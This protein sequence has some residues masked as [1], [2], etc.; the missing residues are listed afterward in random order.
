MQIVDCRG[1]DGRLYDDRERVAC[2]QD[3]KRQV[4][5]RPL[6]RYERRSL[7]IDRIGFWEHVREV[8]LGRESPLE[9]LR[10]DETTPQ[11]RLAEVATVVPLVLESLLT[12]SSSI[13][14]R[15]INI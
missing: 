3:G 1:L 2:L 11:E 7:R 10:R 9:L 5:E 14:P 6:G 13:F 12:S 15:L 4:R 8:E